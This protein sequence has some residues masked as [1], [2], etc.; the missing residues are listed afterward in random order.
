MHLHSTQSTLLLSDHSI[1]SSPLWFWMIVY[2][3]AAC[4]IA[5][6]SPT[7]CTQILMCTFATPYTI[8]PVKWLK[9][10]DRCLDKI[11]NSNRTL[12]FFASIYLCFG[13]VWQSPLTQSLECVYSLLNQVQHWRCRPRLTR[14][15]WKALGVEECSELHQSQS[16]TCQPGLEY[17]QKQ[18]WWHKIMWS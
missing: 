7:Y 2:C 12:K 10:V 9:Q 4:N 6:N 16:C 3:I 17:T 5:L 14:A 13:C 1:S 11:S 15:S 8:F 18:T